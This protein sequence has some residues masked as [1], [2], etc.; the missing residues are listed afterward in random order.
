MPDDPSD[1]TG[2][3]GNLDDL[4]VAISNL[5]I[6]IKERVAEHV[7]NHLRD[8]GKSTVSLLDKEALKVAA[9]AYREAAANPMSIRREE[10]VRA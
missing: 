6:E 8:N 4:L 5:K 7:R 10:R 9:T 2:P 3:P 1:P